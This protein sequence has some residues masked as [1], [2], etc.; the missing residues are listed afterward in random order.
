MTNSV[1]S[2]SNTLRR[3]QLLLTRI[4]DEFDRVCRELEIPYV[5]YGGTAIGAVRH[6]GFIPWDDDADVCMLRADYERF[7]LHAPSVLGEEYEILNSRTDPDYPNMF[8]KVGLKGTRFIPEFLRRSGYQMPIALDVFP[9]DNLPD[10]PREYRAQSRLTWF[11]GR[12][13]YLQGTPVP[14]LE[15]AGVKRTLALAASGIAYWTMRILHVK[16][17][18]LQRR[19]ERA[20][21]RF[22]N[23]PTRRVTDYTDKQPLLWAVER[24]ELFPPRYL[25]FEDIQIPA[26]CQVDSVLTR[27]YGAYMLL[28]PEEKRKTHMPYL[29]DLGPY[30]LAD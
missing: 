11:W 28:P 22:E 7:L 30:S 23:T 1:G 13:L 25:P 15:V 17:R 2:G 6:G 16:P 26:P 19:W 12:L 8:T 20:A 29:V 3:V 21:R 5:A 14:Y 18:A 4:L 10:N 24:D 27:G 9:L